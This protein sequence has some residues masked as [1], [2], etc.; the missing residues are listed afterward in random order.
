MLASLGSKGEEVNKEGKVQLAEQE[1]DLMLLFA[2]HIEREEERKREDTF[3][4]ERVKVGTC[5]S[6][7]DRPFPPTPFD[8]CNYLQYSDHV[9]DT[10][11]MCKRDSVKFTF[12]HNFPKSDSQ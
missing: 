1:A 12:C 3:Q 2:E 7:D 5:D 10:L 11:Y 9:I 8:I 6:I 4:L